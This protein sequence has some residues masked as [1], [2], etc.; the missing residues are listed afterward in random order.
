VITL[1]APSAVFLSWLAMPQ[2]A[3]VSPTA[4][5]EFGDTFNVNPVGTGPF[6]FVSYVPNTEVVLEAN[7]DYFRGAPALQQIIYRIIPDASTRRL[8]LESGNIDLIQQ[9]SQLAAIPAE[10]VRALR[11]NPEITIFESSSQIIRNIDF[12]NNKTDSPVADIRVRQAFSYAVDYDALVTG[13]WGDTAERVYGPLP[14]A[15]WGFNPAIQEN[16]YTRDLDQ[17]KALLAEAGYGE[18]NPLNLTMYTFQGNSWRDVGTLLQANLAEAGINITVEQLEFAQ[19]REIHTGGQFDI[20]LD[21]RQ[22]WYN[23]PDAHIA[24][25]YL[26]SLAGTALNFRMPEDPELDSMIVD[27]QTTTDQEQRKELYFQIQTALMEKV[28]GVYLFA[29]KLI[30]FARSG[31][32]GLVVNTAPPLTE[33]W[34]VSKTAS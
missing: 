9:N 24:I 2:A 5:Q 12:N 31:I 17:A 14:T 21:G 27:A 20:A 7:P 6:R 23:D 15:S 25:G 19:L 10:D 1:S 18:D 32:E 33:Y 30:I 11:D 29:P 16:A 28:P 34:S 13:L 4:A 3:V 22:P 26:S 8:E